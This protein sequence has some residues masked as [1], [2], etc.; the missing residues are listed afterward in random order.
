MRHEPAIA[1]LPAG[2]DPDSVVRKAILGLLDVNLLASVGAG[3]D[4]S[5]TL[6]RAQVRSPSDP[7]YVR[8]APPAMKI[9]RNTSARMIPMSSAVCW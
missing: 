8:T 2:E 1:T 3:D 7:G 6:A 5:V 4:D 9:A